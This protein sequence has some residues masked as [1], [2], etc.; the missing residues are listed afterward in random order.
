MTPG[1][2]M[3]CSCTDRK[4]CEGG[5]NW[6]NTQR[7]V[8]SSC[9]YAKTVAELFA[10]VSAQA[11]RALPPKFDQ[12][13]LEERQAHVMI[14]RHI[15]DNIHRITEEAFEEDQVIASAELVRLATTL[16]QRY[17]E[18]VD[19]ALETETSIVDVVLTLLGEKRIV[20]ATA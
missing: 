3:F 6:A 5:C 10:G 2:C 13:P 12:L 17:P 18:Q 20:L 7:T 11:Q 8:C 19:R 16:R 1:T 15:L 14:T 9:E 4:P